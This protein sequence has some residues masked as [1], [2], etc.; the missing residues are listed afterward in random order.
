[1]LTRLCPLLVCIFVLS[2][3]GQRFRLPIGDETWGKLTAWPSPSGCLEGK[4][5]GDLVQ[6]V[7]H[8]KE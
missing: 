8:A 5:F 6:C 1:M 4:R 7:A 2:S 3:H